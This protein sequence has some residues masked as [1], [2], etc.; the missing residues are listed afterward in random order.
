VAA[1]L[2]VAATSDVTTIAADK[3]SLRMDLLLSSC[4]QQ[5]STVRRVPRWETILT[6]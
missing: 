5:D 1:L 4:Q 6:D 3:Q 2:A